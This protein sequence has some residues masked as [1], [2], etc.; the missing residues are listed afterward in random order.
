MK[1]MQLSPSYTM[2]SEPGARLILSLH[3]FAVL[4]VGRCSHSILAGSTTKASISTGP[5]LCRLPLH[6]SLHFEQV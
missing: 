1:Y 3:K 6:M 2:S 4:Q 5:A